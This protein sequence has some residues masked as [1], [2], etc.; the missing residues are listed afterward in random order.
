M[1]DAAEAAG[2]RLHFDRRM[3]A[4]DFDGSTAQFVDDRDGSRHAHTFTALVG[5]DG[6]GSAVRTAMDARADLGE[7][8]EPLGHGYKEL[9]IPPGGGWRLPLEPNALHIWPRGG[10]MCIALPNDERTFTVTLFLPNQARPQAGEPGFDTVRN[11]AMRMPCSPAI[12]PTH[13]R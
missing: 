3:D 13:C 10:Y 2:A 11:G 8:H 6:A 1:L 7:R 9:E 4:V 5:A 12:S